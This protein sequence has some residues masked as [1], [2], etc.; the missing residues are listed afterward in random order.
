[1][2]KKFCLILLCL[3]CGSSAFAAEQSQE[4]RAVI[5]APAE[6][7]LANTEAFTF[8]FS[9]A[10]LKDKVDLPDKLLL[11]SSLGTLTITQFSD[12]KWQTK[13]GPSPLE[14][15][16]PNTVQK[17]MVTLDKQLGYQ[18]TILLYVT[19]VGVGRQLLGSAE[20]QLK[21]PAK[22]QFTDVPSVVRADGKAV[23]SIS[24]RVTGEQ[25][26]PIPNVPL[27][28][29]GDG[30]ASDGGLYTDIIVAATTDR[31]GTASFVLPTSAR[32]R[33]I[34]NGCGRHDLVFGGDLSTGNSLSNEHRR[35]RRL[36]Y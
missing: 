31:Q 8:L 1:M 5:A 36:A 30:P 25:D 9:L 26:E 21:R 6:I 13:T 14:I 16:R 22:I 29:H 28:I 35:Q 19:T 27:I 23:E 7:Q 33:F 24:V 18:P 15:D 2:L 34:A 4:L 12:G 11:W 20:I 3:V 10:C 17:A 32:H